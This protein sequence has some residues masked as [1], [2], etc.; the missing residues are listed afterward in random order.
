[1][2]TDSDLILKLLPSIQANYGRHASIIIARWE[3][4]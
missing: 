2:S 1:M 3:L 4:N